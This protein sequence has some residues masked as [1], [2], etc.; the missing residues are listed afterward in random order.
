[1]LEIRVK[2]K[3]EDAM[4][5]CIFAPRHFYTYAFFA[6]LHFACLHYCNSAFLHPCN[7]SESK[8]GEDTKELHEQYI[9]IY[10]RSGTSSYTKE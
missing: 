4:H 10:E 3:V 9:I 6:S 7:V 1:M 5:L 8:E 2:K